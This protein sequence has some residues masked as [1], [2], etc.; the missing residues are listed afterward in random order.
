M[1]DRFAETVDIEVL[2]LA[3]GS[4]LELTSQINRNNS[5]FL[6]IPH[7]FAPFVVLVGVTRRK[8]CGLLPNYIHE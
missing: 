3:A 4:C 1:E 7:S 2:L 8:S 5:A 6:F